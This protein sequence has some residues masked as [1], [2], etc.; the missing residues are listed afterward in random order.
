M[1]LYRFLIIFTA[2]TTCLAGAVAKPKPKKTTAPSEFWV[3]KRP[4]ANIENLLPTLVP[5]FADAVLSLTRAICEVKGN[6]ASAPFAEAVQRANGPQLLKHKTVVKDFSTEVRGEIFMASLKDLPNL[7]ISTRIVDGIWSSSL[8]ELTGGGPEQLVRRH[9]FI[10]VTVDD[11]CVAENAIIFN[12]DSDDYLNHV[13]FVDPDINVTRPVYEA[14]KSLVEIYADPQSIP[15][16]R[17]R[18]SI[19]RTA[20]RTDRALVAIYDSGIDYNHP[21]LAYKIPQPP[22]QMTR[23]IEQRLSEIR[24]QLA[25]LKKEIEALTWTPTWTAKK[26]ELNERAQTL[27][28]EGQSYTFGWAFDR[29]DHLP[30]DFVFEPLNP[31]RQFADHGT[32]VG[33]IVTRDSEDIALLPLRYALTGDRDHHAAI[34]YAHSKGARIVNISLGT[35]SPYVFE[36]FE[37]TLDEFKDML[38]IV[39]AGNDGADL[40]VK[41]VWPADFTRPNVIV[42]G[43]THASGAYARGSNYN[44]Q[45]VDLAAIGVDVKSLSPVAMG[46]AATYS[47]TSQAAPQVSRVAAKIKFIDPKMDPIQIREILCKTADKTAELASKVRCGHLNEDAA[48]QFALK[49]RGK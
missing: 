6:V 34:K 43:A 13:Q 20:E 38:F 7:K 16:G 12:Y 41:K 19:F 3:R 1:L 46:G 33:G 8:M 14:R 21:E 2:L 45:K 37:K 42:V 18:A 29:D 35:T 10:R 22:V 44:A 40:A 39:A 23:A 9:E 15:A 47:G 26:A 30:F 32:H 36:N 11:D 17:T 24:T 5:K 31:H 27:R 25:H 28:R 49:N 48:V 4:P